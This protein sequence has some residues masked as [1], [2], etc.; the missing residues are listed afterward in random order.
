MHRTNVALVGFMG[1]GKSTVGRELA[2]RSG[3]R[4]VETD[5]LV[6]ERVGMPIADIFSQHGEP[7]FRELESAVVQEV[8]QL[9]DC[10][11]ACGGGVV[12]NDANVA[13]LRASAVMVYLEVSP[14]SVLERLGPR[15]AVRPL[16][17]GPEREQRVVDLMQQRQPIYAAA[18]ELC[19]P[20]DGLG[21][22]E[23]VRTVERRL[24]GR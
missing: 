15:S 20:T 6:E 12:L 11:I 16:L 9:R 24:V 19:V 22:D 2:A 4:F 5:A 1:C 3:K 7:Y 17:S 13:A 14:A 21:V 23:V 10:V 8:A 18:A